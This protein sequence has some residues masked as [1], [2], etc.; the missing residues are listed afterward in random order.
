[1]QNPQKQLTSILQRK[2]SNF[3]HGYGVLFDLECYK[4]HIL[5]LIVFIFI[6]STF[7]AIMFYTICPKKTINI[8]FDNEV[9]TVEDISNGQS[10]GNLRLAKVS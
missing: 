3:V 7:Y 10:N 9:V 8:I 1:M 4:Q 6:I 5:L 2:I